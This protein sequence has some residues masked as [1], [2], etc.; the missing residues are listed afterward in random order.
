MQQPGGD[1][2]ASGREVVSLLS[3]SGLSVVPQIERMDDNLTPDKPQVRYFNEADKES[4]TKVLETFRQKYP[5]ATLVPLKIP[6]PAGQIE[7]WLP[8]V[9]EPR[10]REPRATPAPPT[11]LRVQ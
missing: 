11:R 3:N 9:S 6:A 7:V 2:P 1:E 5:D 4:A 10:V 8:R